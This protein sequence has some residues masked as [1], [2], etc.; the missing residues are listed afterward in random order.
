MALTRQGRRDGFEKF[1]L[2]DILEQLP[3]AIRWLDSIKLG[4][5]RKII[6]ES[7]AVLS[8]FQSKIDSPG[9]YEYL[10]TRKIKEI[11]NSA[12]NLRSIIRLYRG[13]SLADQNRLPKA[14]LKEIME[15]PLIPED[16]TKGSANV[17]PR[18]TL[19]ELETASRLLESG[20]RIFEFDDANFVYEDINI[21]VE[22][23]RIHS[24]SQVESNF[25]KALAQ[26]HD[27]FKGIDDRGIVAISYDKTTSVDDVI[28]TVDNEEQLVNRS[29]KLFLEFFAITKQYF[30]IF[31][32][33]RILGI[34][35]TL[36]FIYTKPGTSILNPFYHHALL[37]MFPNDSRHIRDKEI[38]EGIYQRLKI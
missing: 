5:N 38:Y 35:F 4:G 10:T 8:E 16:E 24:I 28:Y 37:Q 18:N 19:F 36:K 26:V 3:T 27:E 34:Y 1:D 30:K 33:A 13:F 2:D 14:K 15:M 6:S 22:C 11:F 21:I 31:E 25:K 9:F 32:K 20:F 17:N 12:E 23:K 29:E 7:R